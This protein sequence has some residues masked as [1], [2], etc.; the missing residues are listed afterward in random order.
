MP[1]RIRGSPLLI[2]EAAFVCSQTAPPCSI[3]NVRAFT[4]STPNRRRELTHRQRQT[5]RWHLNNGTDKQKQMRMWLYKNGQKLDNYDG[6]GSWGGPS[7]PFPDNPLFKSQPVLSDF[8]K[9]L[10][11]E[12]ITHRGQSLKAVSAEM[13]V[14]VRRVAAVVRMKEV[15]AQWK[16]EVGLVW[17]YPILCLFFGRF[18]SAMMISNNSR[19]VLKTF[20]WLLYMF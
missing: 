13:S 9:N 10:I 20:P 7:E 18:F 17:Y 11:F 6:S 19:L 1:P 12:K 16:N 14:D 5:L 3:A 4:A 2:G 15:E 8:M